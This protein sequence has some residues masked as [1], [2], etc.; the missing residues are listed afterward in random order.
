LP[1]VV[2]WLRA[3]ATRYPPPVSS[4]ARRLLAGITIVVAAGAR[5][6]SAHDVEGAAQS[7]ALI[8]DNGIAGVRAFALH[9]RPGG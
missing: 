9:D 8:I 6:V 1:L 5:L 7:P 2:G 3:P 4:V